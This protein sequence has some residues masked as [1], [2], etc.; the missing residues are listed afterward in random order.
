MCGKVYKIIDKTN[1]NVYFG[2]TTMELQDRLNKHKY[3]YNSFLKHGGKKSTSCEIIQNGDFYI[4]LVEEINDLENLKMRERFYIENNECVNEKVPYRT[5]AEIAQSKR[6]WYL[7]NIEL[8]KERA[9]VWEQNNKERYDNSKKKWTE[10]NK[11]RI[12]Q[13]KQEWLDKNRERVNKQR[14]ER[15]EAKKNVDI[16]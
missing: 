15:R 14:R 1:N 3:A 6:D 7:Q 8:S 11:E 9:R 13:Y 10:D 16:V 5:T 12:R 2:S 4:E